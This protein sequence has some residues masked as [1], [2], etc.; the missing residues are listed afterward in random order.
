MNKQTNDQ[1]GY[2]DMTWGIVTGCHGPN[3]TPCPYCYAKRITQRWKNNYPYGFDPTFWPIR[4][5]DPLTRKKPAR[6][7]VADMADLFGKWDWRYADEPTYIGSWMA[8]DVIIG[9]VKRC[10]QHT[11]LFLT[12]NPARYADFDWPDNCELGTTITNQKDADERSWQLLKAGKD[13]TVTWWSVEPMQGPIDISALPQPTWLAIGA[14]NG[15]GV[16]R[17]QRT[18][19]DHLMD[20]CASYGVPYWL[21]SMEIGGRHIKTLEELAGILGRR[22]FRRLPGMV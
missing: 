6:I 2:C 22:D 18:W 14:L 3:G 4:L 7:F 20:Q 12:K 16:P 9:V 10:P 21:K 15:P 13:T 17:T 1:I 11:F 5:S 19:I 8:I